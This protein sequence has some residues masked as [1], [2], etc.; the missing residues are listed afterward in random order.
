M[1]KIKKIVQMGIIFSLIF[2][3][4]AIEKNLFASDL[5][6][7]LKNEDQKLR[8]AVMS[9]ISSRIERLFQIDPDMRGLKTQI[10]TSLPPQNV[11]PFI[12]SKFNEYFMNSENYG[13]YASQLLDIINNQN[14]T[15]EFQQ[16]QQDP[17]F[18]KKFASFVQTVYKNLKKD[19]KIQ[20]LFNSH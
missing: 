9:E 16:A 15:S 6:P 17:D 8:E 14:N 2:S 10:E 1:N 20:Q 12:S 13:D 18:D 19:Q 11:K 5:N 3:L 4:S 7:T